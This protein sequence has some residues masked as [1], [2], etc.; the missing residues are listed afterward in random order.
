MIGDY[1]EVY[2]FDYLMEQALIQVPNTVDKRQG[3]IIYDA[4]APACYR[5][6]DFYNTLRNVY[7][8][9]F[10]ETA[11]GESLDYRVAEQGIKRYLAT[12]AIKKGYFAS[13]AAQ[14]MAIPLGA[15]F[16]TISDINPI[17]YTVIAAHAEDG[18]VQPG[19]YQLKCETAG[20]VGNEY[21]GTLTNITYIQGL[22]SAT[23]S[24]LINPARDEETDE[25]LRTRYFEMVNQKAFGGNIAQYDQELKDISGVGDVQIYPVW[26]GGGTVKLSI[27]DSQYHKCSNEFIGI[28]QNLVDPENSQ[29]VTGTG[30]G[31]APIG[32]K[33]TVVT[34]T[35]Y[36]ANITATVVLM[37]GMSIGQV[38]APIKNAIEAYF[39]TLR[40][41]WGMSDEYNDYSLG[42]YI[43]RIT[44]A[45]LTVPG[46]A[47]VTNVKINGSSSD[48]TLIEN[49]TTQQL[50]MVGTVTINE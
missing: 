22:A 23:M 2:T 14:P 31:I 38:S 20:V 5:L 45:I 42:I 11:T 50:P 24:E 34:A 1:L 9:T 6:A 29:G 16:S 19:Y 49:A 40:K 17:T 48:I 8:D 27:V 18:V 46:V 47:N 21:S 41:N 4:L 35:E 43:S 26:N 36:T 15:R 39:E 7:K 3:S 33:V 28:V 13:A 25:A 32:H 12:Y 10:A 44:A 37:S 30:L